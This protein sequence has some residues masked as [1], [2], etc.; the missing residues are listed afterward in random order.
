V[1][2]T[3]LGH[4]PFLPVHSCCPLAEDVHDLLHLAAQ[5]ALTAG[6]Q[7]LSLREYPITGEAST[8]LES[9]AATKAS[10]NWPQWNGSADTGNLTLGTSK[11]MLTICVGKGSL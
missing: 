5:L 4:L 3:H 11:G 9:N 6:I 8:I 1:L 10:N 2:L 7:W